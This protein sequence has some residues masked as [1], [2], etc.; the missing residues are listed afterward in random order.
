MITIRR[1][2]ACAAAFAFFALSADAA[3]SEYCAQP[4]EAAALKTA[5]IQQ[6][7]M[8]AALTCRQTHLYNRFVIAYR[9]DLRRSDATL[10][11]YFVRHHGRRAGTRAYHA[12]KT[13]LANAASLESLH[14]IRAYCG[15]ARAVFHTAL[16]SRRSLAQ[17]VAVVSPRADRAT[18]RAGTRVAR[19]GSGE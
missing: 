19:A 13:K 12:Y 10:Q 11:H 16:D 2:V 17:L 18:C 14:D 5:A 15:D 9:R 8:V 7:L 1:S 6:R 3:A 4:G